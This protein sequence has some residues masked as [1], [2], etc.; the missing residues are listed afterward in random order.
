MRR[1]MDPAIKPWVENWELLERRFWSVLQVARDRLSPSEL[2][3]R[4]IPEVNSVGWNLQHL[5]E[6]LDYYLNVLFELDAP[7]RPDHPTMLRGAVDDGRYRDIG[8]ITAYHRLIRPA[9]RTFLEGLSVAD[10]EKRPGRGQVT[11][12][13]AIGHI[14]EHESYHIGKCTLLIRLIAAR[15]SSGH[16]PLF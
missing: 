14:H 12:G 11:I 4:P 13:W 16:T 15:R 8:E 10:F 5:A 1:S 7:I 6:M 2:A 3:W 9:Y